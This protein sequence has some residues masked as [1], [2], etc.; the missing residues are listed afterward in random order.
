MFPFGAPARNLC[1][2]PD[3][4]QRARLRCVS[5][6]VAASPRELADRVL[7]AGVD[8]IAITDD[9]GIVGALEARVHPPAHVIVGEQVRCEGN[10]EMVGSFW[11]ERIPQGLSIEETVERIRAQG[12][13]VYAPRPYAYSS[14]RRCHTVRSPA[15]ADIMEVFK[16][17]AFDA[18][19]N[20]RAVKA[21]RARPR[22]R[23]LDGLALRARTRPRSHG[24]PGVRGPER[25]PRALAQG[26]PVAVAT[27][28]PSIHPA[29]IGLEATRLLVMP[30]RCAP[31]RE[32]SATIEPLNAD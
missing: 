8:R 10:A 11:A 5:L 29:S 23:R 12:G 19:W 14:Q 6:G 17:R 21:A 7:E 27:A 18:A 9:G 28:S 30:S 25:L 16:S 20:R 31:S 13:P 26:T 24:G 22:P 3:R 4:G 1:G 32:R 2:A 15:V